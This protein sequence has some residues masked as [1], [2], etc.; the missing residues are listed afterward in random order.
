[1]V[2]L[3]SLYQTRWELNLRV[4]IF[5]LSAFD[6]DKIHVKLHKLNTN[7]NQFEL[8]QK[9]YRIFD[10]IFILESLVGPKE[11]S[12]VS[13][14]GFDPKITVTCNSKTFIVCNRNKIVE[15]KDT[16]EPLSQLR[17]IMPKISDDRFR[18]IGG[19]VGY[20]S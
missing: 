20:I 5:G 9:F 14:I 3:F 1:M 4:D 8:F 10:K 15:E 16:T 18:Y 11:L 12:E 19:A 7:Y 6:N 2:S 13:I 17:K